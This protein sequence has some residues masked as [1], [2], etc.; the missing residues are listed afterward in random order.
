[1]ITRWCDYYSASLLSLESLASATLLILVDVLLYVSDLKGEIGKSGNQKAEMTL[2]ELKTISWLNSQ[3]ERFGF[4]KR[5]RALCV[6][7]EFRPF[8]YVNA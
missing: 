2:D 7:K 3:T 8:D 6:G 1:M 5:V 4:L